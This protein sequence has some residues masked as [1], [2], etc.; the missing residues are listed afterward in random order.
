MN[1]IVLIAALIV[2]A[3]RLTVAPGL[4]VGDTYK[5]LAHLFVGGVFGASLMA[6]V[7]FRRFQA[8]E[9]AHE[10]ARRYL[11][12]GIGLT[13]LEVACGVFGKKTGVSVVEFV[14]RLFS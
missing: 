4:D 3:V 14:Q 10:A 2:V 8:T 1:P 12:L 7:L 6:F 13:V 11:G 9:R 5:D